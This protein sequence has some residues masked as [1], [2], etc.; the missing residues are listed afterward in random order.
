MPLCTLVST[1]SSTFDVI[2]GSHAAKFKVYDQIF[3]MRRYEMQWNAGSDDNEF[4]ALQFG[5]VEK[6]RS[7]FMLDSA[8]DLHTFIT[9]SLSEVTLQFPQIAFENFRSRFNTSCY[10]S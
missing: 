4:S 5:D 3:G 10:I 1:G 7:R 9:M 6:R 8:M 2:V